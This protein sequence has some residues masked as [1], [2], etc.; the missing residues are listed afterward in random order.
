MP[1]VDYLRIG[2]DIAKREAERPKTAYERLCE[3]IKAGDEQ[4]TL[5]DRDLVLAAREALRYDQRSTAIVAL[6]ELALR[7]K[8]DEPVR[9]VAA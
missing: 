5:C 4:F 6:E 3:A 9:D 8:A 2:L 1:G 7:K